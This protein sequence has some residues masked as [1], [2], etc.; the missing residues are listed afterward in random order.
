M[1]VDGDN[2]HH[3][4]SWRVLAARKMGMA[5]VP[6]IELAHLSEAQKKGVHHRRQQAGTECRLG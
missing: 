2:G 1:L 6:C 3:C 5:E 4:R